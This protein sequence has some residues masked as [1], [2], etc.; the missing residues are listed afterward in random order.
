MIHSS[1]R[2][3]GLLVSVLALATFGVIAFAPKAEASVTGV[4]ITSP[5]VPALYGTAP[6]SVDITFDLDVSHTSNYCATVQV[7]G[8][9][10]VSQ[11]L[12]VLTGG[13]TT[14]HTVTVPIPAGTP[15]GA[16]DAQV[17]VDEFDCLVGFSQTDTNTGV[18]LIAAGNC[19]S[20]GWV[21]EAAAAGDLFDA[22]GDGFIC[23][24]VLPAGSKG[25]GNSANTQRGTGQTGFHV[26][27]HNHKDNN[28]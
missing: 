16:Y 22:N 12:G 10:T 15:A 6:T 27:G 24:K 25:D 13:G 28:N 8:V 21:I 7:V 19:P 14:T 11:T 20:G 4:T 17:R 26:D 3:L 9:N 18:V 23:T 1:F 5:V 2:R